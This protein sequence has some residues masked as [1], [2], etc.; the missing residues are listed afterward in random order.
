[1]SLNIR[2]LEKWGAVRSVWVKG[3]RKDYYEADLDV[4]KVVGNK[5]KT[6]IQKRV[7]EVSSMI[8]DFKAIVQSATGELTE[9][10]RHIV[11]IYEERLKKIEELKT[12]VS[13]AMSLAEKLL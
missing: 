3:S 10:E 7:Q 12:L 8:D 4:K 2:E 6:G 1:V 5:L 13:N 11:K 9:E